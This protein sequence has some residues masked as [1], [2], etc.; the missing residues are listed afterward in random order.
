MTI[1]VVDGADESPALAYIQGRGAEGLFENPVKK[2][3]FVQDWE[4]GIVRCQYPCVYP[5]G[6]PYYGGGA[7]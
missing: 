4:S 3:V 1:I 2:S 6:I 7:G 5:S